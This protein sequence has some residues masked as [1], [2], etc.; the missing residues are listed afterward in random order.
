[1]ALWRNQINHVEELLSKMFP[2]K[3]VELVKAIDSENLGFRYEIKLHPEDWRDRRRVED[4]VDE[5]WERN[6]Y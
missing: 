4:A 5:S 3:R 6:K 2:G 1:M